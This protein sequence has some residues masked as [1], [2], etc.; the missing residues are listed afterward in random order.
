MHLSVIVKL[1]AASA[2][3]A[4]ICLA[5]APISTP[6]PY[7]KAAHLVAFFV[8]TL[9]FSLA[10]PNTAKLVIPVALITLGGA[11]ELIQG[12]TALGHEADVWDS[13]ADCTGV[14][15]ALVVLFLCRYLATH[16]APPQPEQELQTSDPAPH[17]LP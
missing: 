7:D 6:A 14:A 12:A 3:G 13:V 2:L 1:A 11:I 4:V 9:V 10:W 15:S 16:A 5:L 17:I 8:L